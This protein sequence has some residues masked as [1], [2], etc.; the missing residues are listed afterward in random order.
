VSE[1]IEK[2]KEAVEKAYE[3][4]ARHVVSEEVTDLFQG[5]VAWDAVVAIFELEEY[6]KAKR[7]YAWAHIEDGEPQYT[8]VLEIP[9]VNSAESALEVAIARRDRQ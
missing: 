6:P 9:P 5:E 8:T 3:C 1:R 2:L 4:K 7:C